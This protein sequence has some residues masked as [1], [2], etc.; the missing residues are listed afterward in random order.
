MPLQD[1]PLKKELRE[2]SCECNLKSTELFE[3]ADRNENFSYYWSQDL[4]YFERWSTR[5]N[6]F[7][8][9][10]VD[11]EEVKTQCVNSSKKV[12]CRWH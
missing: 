10:Q 7:I 11:S 3:D 6:A 4:E 5:Q 12:E 2:P 1:K 9:E 8:L